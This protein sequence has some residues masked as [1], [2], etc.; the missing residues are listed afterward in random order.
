MP[1]QDELLSAVNVDYTPLW[2]LGVQ[3]SS[4]TVGEFK[5]EWDSAVQVDFQQRQNG[6]SN[7]S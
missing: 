6:F 7:S 2:K 1:E 3:Q 5:N 4:D